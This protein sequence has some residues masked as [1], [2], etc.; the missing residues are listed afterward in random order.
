MQSSMR[1]IVVGIIVFLSVHV[2]HAQN[3]FFEDAAGESA[4]K[5][6]NTNITVNTSQNAIKAY[7]D[8]KDLKNCDED[9]TF[10][11]RTQ[12]SKRTFLNSIKYRGYVI[13]DEHTFVADSNFV[14][15]TNYTIK[16][17]PIK[18]GEVVIR[19]LC[20]EKKEDFGISI[21][22]IANNGISNLFGGGKLNP[23]GEFKGVY[24]VGI[25]ESKLNKWDKVIVSVGVSSNIVTLID[26]SSLLNGSY[27]ESN[28]G[29]NFEVAYNLVTY[30]KKSSVVFG[31]S[32][33]YQL[34][35]N[36]GSLN[37][38]TY[39][40]QN[41]VQSVGQVAVFQQSTLEGINADTYIA[42][43]SHINLNVDAG[44]SPHKLNDRL[45]IAF[46]GRAKKKGEDDFVLNSG[47]GLFL[48]QKEVSTKVVGGISFM[49]N[50]ITSTSDDTDLLDKLSINVVTGFNF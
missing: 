5:M 4:F 17:A 36:S 42:S 31:A 22:A 50:D 29:L 47:L 3:S 25:G 28:F 14:N 33:S 40:V 35:D 34:Q 38:S 13:I 6:N 23:K 45:M 7:I 19:V 44:I 16:P 15:S 26:T 24:E 41:T 12:K 1:K 39:T 37:N 10:F 46:Q 27:N 21:N 2:L 9:V 30:I 8:V 18:Y 11:F 32:L 48:A 43:T 20:K 49:F